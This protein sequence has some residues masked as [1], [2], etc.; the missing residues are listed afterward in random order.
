MIDKFNLTILTKFI[1]K[2]QSQGQA[3]P[4]YPNPNQQISSNNGS[5]PPKRYKLDEMHPTQLQQQPTP[6]VFLTPQQLQMLQHLQK[7][8]DNLTVQ[9]QNA[10][11][12]LSNQH[13]L[14]IQYQQQLHLQRTQIQQHQQN[15]TQ[16]SPQNVGMQQPNSNYQPHV[17]HPTNPAQ[18]NFMDNNSDELMSMRPNTGILFDNNDM[19]YMSQQNENKNN[20]GNYSQIT[21]TT[22]QP[23]L[24]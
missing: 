11:Q 22:S 24:G 12:Q 2:F 6:P 21:S 19:N 15:L 16:H 13:R 7:H 23:D 17:M 4:P 5:I 1:F 10:Y 9:Q 20:Y 18:T 8:K 14:M 3:P